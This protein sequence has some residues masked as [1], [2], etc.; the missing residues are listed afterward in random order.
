MTIIGTTLLRCAVGTDSRYIG[1]AIVVISHRQ[2][3]ANARVRNPVVGTYMQTKLLFLLISC[4][5]FSSSWVCLVMRAARV[6]SSLADRPLL[7]EQPGRMACHHLDAVIDGDVVWLQIVEALRR[8]WGP[9]C[10]SSVSRGGSWWPMM[11]KLVSRHQ[12]SEAVES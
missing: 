3:S 9:V 11:T 1:R 8:I 12:K 2:S 10:S 7:G 5:Y 6:H 4:S